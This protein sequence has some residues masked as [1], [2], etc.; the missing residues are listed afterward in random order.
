MTSL[1]IVERLA[2]ARIVP[3]IRSASADQAA[4]AAEWLTE[5]GFGVLEFTL[6][7][8]GAFELV[9]ANRQREDALVG[10]GT[11]LSAA[12]ADRGIA[13]GAR[14]LVTPCWVDGV[15]E[16]CNEAGVPAL[17]GAGSAAEIWRAHGAGAAVVKVFPA[18]AVGGPGFL[19][20]VRAVF[21]Q[22]PLMPTGGFKPDD[23]RDYL[24]AGAVCVG[25]GG[26]L[27]PAPMIARGARAEVVA[28]GRKLLAEARA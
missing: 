22:I 9:A 8:P 10:I 28:L 11:V 1:T 23:V 7:T 12:D 19:K 15:I 21:P 6:T 4:T 14:F 16:R 5:A 24:A 17:I 26:E 25:M 18:A 2:A 3:V 27:A 20:S 13:A